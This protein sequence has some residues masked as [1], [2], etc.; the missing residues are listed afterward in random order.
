MQMNLSVLKNTLSDHDSISPPPWRPRWIRDGR[1]RT[2]TRP[3]PP[4]LPP[5]WWRHR[6]RRTSFS[7]LL[8]KQLIRGNWGARNAPFPISTQLASDD[9]MARNL[10]WESCHLP[11]FKASFT[12]FICSRCDDVIGKLV[13]ME[14]K[15]VVWA[16][17]NW[18]IHKKSVYKWIEN[19]SRAYIQINWNRLVPMRSL[20]LGAS[21]IFWI[22]CSHGKI[23][24]LTDKAKQKL[25]V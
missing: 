13:I 20:K 14:I 4:P 6:R 8:L 25:L 7:S 10:K 19:I 18:E 17:L 5:S 21:S 24:S 16:M 1:R 2:P 3:P 23:T 12:C 11:Q 22:A 9:D 15:S